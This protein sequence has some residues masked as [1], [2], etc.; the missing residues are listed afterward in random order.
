M[1]HHYDVVCLGMTPGI[2]SA[3]ALLARRTFRVLVVGEGF[4]RARYHHEGSALLRRQRPPVGYDSPV[5]A[6]VR[7]E[8]AEEPTWR[9]RAPLLDPMFRLDWAEGKALSVPPSLERFLAEV[10]R[11]DPAERAAVA[12]FYP[13]LAEYNAALDGLL[14]SPAALFGDGFLARRKKRNALAEL[15]ALHARIPPGPRGKLGTMLHE[16]TRFAAPLVD[17]PPLAEARLHGSWTRGLTRLEGG[18]DALTDLLVDRIRSSGG[19]VEAGARVTSIATKGT[20]VVSV[21]LDDARAPVQASFV[22]TVTPA[23]TF[24]RKLP[25]F[26]PD[27]R[28]LASLY[29]PRPVKART[30]T[31]FVVRNGAVPEAWPEECIVHRDGQPTLCVHVERGPETTLLAV[32]TDLTPAEVPEGRERV[33]SA[34]AQAA[35]ELPGN[36]YLVDSVHD[37]APLWDYRSG[38][39]VLVPRSELRDQGSAFEEPEALYVHESDDP[40]AGERLDSI[41]P[42]VFVV[43]PTAMPA[44]GLEGE[45]VTALHVAHVITKSDRTR[46]KMRRE[47]WSKLE[48]DS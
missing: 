32:A 34:L 35:P 1:S 13:E 5:F 20:R 14:P 15:A 3:A 17:L 18:D 11:T 10:E 43:G 25:D 24:F 45:L 26:S 41:L 31:S 36:L 40:F 37:R 28:D 21:A 23:R 29:S 19:T 7:L 38:Q 2:L 8:L 9:R 22:L 44:L 27:A 48:A 16:L 33:L 39:R 12:A 47:L 6:R 4:R 46:E 42:N 30:S